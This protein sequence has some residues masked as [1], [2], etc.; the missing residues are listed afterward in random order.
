MTPGRGSESAVAW[1]VLGTLLTMGTATILLL[2]TRI[3]RVRIHQ[4]GDALGAD[5]VSTSG[6][7]G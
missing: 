2:L 1:I 3:E 4:S 7:H 6:P 5:P